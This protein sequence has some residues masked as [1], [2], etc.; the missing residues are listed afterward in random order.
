MVPT[1]TQHDLVVI[2]GGP[3]GY[4]AALYGAA[5]GLD[6]GLV[7]M[8][9]VGGTCLHVGCI[10][11]KELL[12]SAAVF[13]T[14]RDASEFGVDSSEPKIDLGR[15]Q[16]R[17]QNVVDTLAKGVSSLLKGRKVTV[18]DGTGSLVG[19]GT[20]S[21]SGGES[22][23]ETLEAESVIL[24]AGSKP[25]SIPGLDIDGQIVMTSDEFLSIDRV[26]QSAVVVG[27]GA[28][29]CEFASVLGDLGTDVTIVEAL[30][31]ILPGVDADAVKVVERSFAK[32]GIKI[33]TEVKVAGHTPRSDGSGTVV[34]L[35]DDSLDVDIVVVAV[36]RR[37]FPDF[38]GLD[39][40]GVSVDDRGFVNVDELCRTNVDGVWAVGDLV[41]TPQL[42]HV[43]FA[44]AIMVIKDILG[45]AAMPVDYDKVPWCIYC[46]PEVA[47][48]GHTEQSA[49][50]AGYDVAVSKHRFAG[51]SRAMIIG[52]PEGLVKII[53]EKDADGAAGTILGVH[54]VGPWV[55]EQLGQGYMAVNWEATVAEASAFIQ[56]HPTLS[57]L[58]G[59]T[60]LS[61]T[62]RAL[63]G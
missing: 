6:I 5:A 1:A 42:A 2:G 62:G 57:E 10:P 33:R 23:D 34:D 14:V 41:A 48:V 45:E 22:G 17:K 63:H 43:A 36:G 29:G 60:L 12:E 40:A 37:P 4:G 27:G 16:L 55:T 31:Q 61:M 51:N 47:F 7:E 21:V 3:G 58:F 9:K 8:H 11:A 24:A 25:R 49:V 53:A 44:E 30:P 52:E 54:M 15:T 39:A 19:P 18:Y 13:R 35:G 32:R 46:H 38:L 20:V 28:I 56:P 50:D 26:P 59:E